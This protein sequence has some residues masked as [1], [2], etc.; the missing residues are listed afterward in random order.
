MLPAHSSPSRAPHRSSASVAGVKC[1]SARGRDIGSMA[2]AT[3]ASSARGRDTGSPVRK[4]LAGRVGMF[5]VCVRDCQP[6][7]APAECWWARTNTLSVD[8]TSLGDDSTVLDL[9]T[10]CPF[11]FFR[12][13]GTLGCTSR[14]LSRCRKRSA[15]AGTARKTPSPQRASSA[16][17][18]FRMS[19]FHTPIANACIPC[20]DEERDRPRVLT[21]VL[22]K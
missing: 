21:R 15:I 8:M 10:S 22:R 20:P 13:D 18:P 17:C 5:F 19:E 6:C 11:D 2:W 7:A 4:N 1:R 16:Q 14:T 3:G 9:L 12:R